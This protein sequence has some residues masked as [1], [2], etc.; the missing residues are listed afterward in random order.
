[1]GGSAEIQSW[2]TLIVT[3]KPSKGWRITES[4]KDEGKVRRTLWK[5][6]SLTTSWKEKKVSLEFPLTEDRKADFSSF[7]IENTSFFGVLRDI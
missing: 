5:G 2:E 7:S 3:E 6:H 1:M 4:A